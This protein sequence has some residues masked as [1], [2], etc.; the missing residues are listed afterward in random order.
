[1][2]D[3]VYGL[4][5]VCLSHRIEVPEP[6]R[7]AADQRPD[8]CTLCHVDRTRAWAASAALRWRARAPGSAKADADAPQTADSELPEQTYRILAG[9]PI[10]RAVAAHALGRTGAHYAH[11]YAAQLIGLLL[12]VS[13]ADPYPAVRGIASRSLRGVLAQLHPAAAAQLAAY[14]ATGSAD[15]RKL[16]MQGLSR[17]LGAAIVLPEASLSARL[18]ALS[19]QAAIEIGE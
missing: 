4:V 17:T 7:Q 16:V 18:R 14:S 2:P 5:S 12:D 10:E 11:G 3:V 8:A 13:V 6:A 15:E 1:M 19:Q 9:D